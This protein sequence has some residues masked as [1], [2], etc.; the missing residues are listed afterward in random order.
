MRWWTAKTISTL[1]LKSSAILLGRYD[2]TG[3]MARHALFLAMMVVDRLHAQYLGVLYY[4]GLGGR[5]VARVPP[6]PA[7]PRPRDREGCFKA[8]LN[9]NWV[10]LAIFLGIALDLQFRLKVF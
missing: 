6:V 4:A 7:D 1:G 8:F 5:R 9:N 2:V 10:G 3:V